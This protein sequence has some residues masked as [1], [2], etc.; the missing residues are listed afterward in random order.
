MSIVSRPV[1]KEYANNYDDVYGIEIE[2]DCAIC[3]RRLKVR[4]SKKAFDAKQD[5]EYTCK[6]CGCTNTI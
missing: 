2:L 4:V 5:Q 6:Y 3:H 1:T